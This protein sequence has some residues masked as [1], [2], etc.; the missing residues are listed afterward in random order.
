MKQIKF[1]QWV[2]GQFHYWGVKIGAADFTGPASGNKQNAANTIHQQFTGL[3]D[4]NGKEIYE[5]DVCRFDANEIEGFNCVL[6]DFIGVVE[7]DEEDAGF[8]YATNMDK[9]PHI[10]PWFA[11][12]VEVIGNVHETPELCKG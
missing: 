1:R 7:W 6:C 10:K 8:Y 4:R 3:Y 5:G 2:N 11:V 9:W 12:N